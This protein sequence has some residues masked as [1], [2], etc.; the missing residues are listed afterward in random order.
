MSIR[1]ILIDSRACSTT[2]GFSSRPQHVNGLT[3][4]VPYATM[5]TRVEIQILA[6]TLGIAA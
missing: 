6:C 5:T 1:H 2:D 4:P 3:T